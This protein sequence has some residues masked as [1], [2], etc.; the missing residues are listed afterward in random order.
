[1]IE[2]MQIDININLKN[3]KQNNLQKLIDDIKRMNNII[4]D[5]RF[6]HIAKPLGKHLTAYFN[7]ISKGNYNDYKVYFHKE[8]HENTIHNNRLL[9]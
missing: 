5:N 4:N 2:K 7:D 8:N 9:L 6:Y 3:V 1:M